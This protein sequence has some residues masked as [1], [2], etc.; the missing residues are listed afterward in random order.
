VKL[1]GTLWASPNARKLLV[2]SLIDSAGNGVYVSAGVVL[3]SIVLHLSSTQVA[4]GFSVGAMVGLTLSVWWGSLADRLG[5]RNVLTSLQVWRAVGC[6]AFIFANN[7]GTYVAIVVFLGIAERASPPILLAFVTSAL[8][9]SNRVKIAGTLR[10]VR[11]AGYTVGALGASLA[12]I[13]PGRTSMAVVVL[14]NSA[15]FVFAAITLRRMP[16]TEEAKPLGR[17]ARRRNASL[18][19]GRRPAFLVTTALTGL[20]S[21]HR[22]I[23]SIGLPLWIATRK[24]APTSVVGVL[25]AVNTVLVVVLQVRMTKKSE[26]AL[27]AARV[28]R[29][30]A[31]ALLAFAGLLAVSLVQMP[32]RPWSTIGVL[33]VATILLTLAEMWQAAGAWGLSLALSPAAARSRFLSVFNLG[34]SALDVTGALMLTAWVLPASWTGWL[35]LGGVLALTGLLAPPVAR[36]AE[37]ERERTEAP[38]VTPDGH[39]NG[40]AVKFRTN[41]VIRH[42]A[43]SRHL[44]W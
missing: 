28:L 22:Q 6:A 37:R 12:L 4:Q 29:L 34:S 15:S 31:L 24:L 9:Q 7:F 40:H 19:I 35:V 25:V 16:L 11:N 17:R 39:H 23:L 3:F 2:V 8:G 5:V 10:S 38:A 43:G 21:I 14:S 20:L 26:E 32:Y 13:S 44:T 30:A 27:G 33:V 18:K 41:P 1:K 42:R 36:W